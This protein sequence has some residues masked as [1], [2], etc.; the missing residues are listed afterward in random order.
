VKATNKTIIVTGA[1]SGTGREICLQLLQRQT[2][3]AAV[4]INIHALKET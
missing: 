4:D 1:G 3:I 2:M